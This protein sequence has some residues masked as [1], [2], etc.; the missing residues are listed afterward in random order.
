MSSILLSVKKISHP[1]YLDTSLFE[2]HFYRDKNELLLK[3]GSNCVTLRIFGHLR[4]IPYCET[5]G[6]KG[7]L[8][9]A[10]S[11]LFPVFLLN[12]IVHIV[13]SLYCIFNTMR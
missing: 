2:C 13:H 11:V 12:S 1:Q 6:Q 10:F 9:S 4:V 7:P 5:V 8:D 3:V